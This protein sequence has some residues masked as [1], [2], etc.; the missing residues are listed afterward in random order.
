[1]DKFICRLSILF[2]L[3]PIYVLL[4]S[5]QSL[6]IAE[7]GLYIR[8]RTLLAGY[9]TLVLLW[10]CASPFRS[11]C[12]D[13]SLME[14]LFYWVPMELFGL[15]VFAQW[16]FAAAAA[17]LAALALSLVLVFVYARAEERRLTAQQGFSKERRRRYNRGLK[18]AAVALTALFLVVPC[19]LSV[20]VYHLESPHYE[21]KAAVSEA[22]FQKKVVKKQP[23]GSDAARLACFG[24]EVWGELNAEERLAAAQLLLDYETERLGIPAMRLTAGMMDEGTLGGYNTETREIR[25]DAAHLA[26]ASAALCVNTVCHEAWHA[27]QYFILERV[28]WENEVF[29]AA[30]FE[31]LRDWRD[32]SE[33]YRQSDTD[34]YAAY[35]EQPLERAARAYAKEETLRIFALLG[36][37][38]TGGEGKTNVPEGETGGV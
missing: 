5:G 36:E 16:Q 37:S 29:S 23:E 7:V 10:L 19:A 27:Q 30:Y 14:S 8:W 38:L 31:E 1:M 34:G 35:Y 17:T 13:G 32:N 25:V 24:Q 12:A 28:D 20:C 18:R 6:S 21:A 26:E 4:A 9:I 11:A 22:L 2:S 33:T 3:L 15:M